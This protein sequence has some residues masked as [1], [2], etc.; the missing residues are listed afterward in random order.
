M[1]QP[2][3][4]TL[5][6]DFWERW[7]VWFPD[8]PPVGFLLR[9]AYPDRWLRIHFLPGGKRQ[10][11]SGLEY[12]EA[13]RRI[14]TICTRVLGENSPL[15][16]LLLVECDSK[17][18]ENAQNASGLSESHLQALGSLSESLW[19]SENGVFSVPMCVYGCA[20]R[21]MPADF[22]IL[23]GAAINDLIKPLLVEIAQGTVIAPYHGGVDAFF[24]SDVDRDLAKEQLS[25]W[26]SSRP[27]AL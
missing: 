18:L 15:A 26:T 16:L 27:D 7:C 2:F 5:G 10:P 12:A 23:F 3:V 11:T 9:D 24:S 13:I 8:A 1:K 19:H 4:S 20:S 22:D 6:A 14:N 17:A 25:L 21:W